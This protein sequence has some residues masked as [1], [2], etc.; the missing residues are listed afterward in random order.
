MTLLALKNVG[1]RFGGLKALD[2]VS[3]SVDSGEIV[4]I[5]G[6]NGAGKTTLFSL[7]AGHQKPGSGHILFDGRNI[8][9]LRPDAINRRGI[10]RTFQ[11]VRPFRS[12]T[13]RENVMIGALFG[14][15]AD[16]TLAAAEKDA[17]RILHEV[18]LAG[19]A[20]LPAG[21]LTLAGQKRLEIARALATRP[22]LLLLDEV[23]AGL[24]PT[25][26]AAARDMIRRLHKDHALT[27]LIIEHV[28]TA[29]MELGRR[30]V[31]LHHG[32]KIAEGTPDAIAASPRVQEAYLGQP[33]A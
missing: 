11:I 4:G 3:L 6:A 17:A 12:M 16:E 20:D 32:L 33:A 7:I 21:A 23:M 29:L 22:R 9:G 28:M 27:I 10:A 13:V 1:I 15:G 2:D 5:M 18:G 30:I 26:V 14:A 31:V 24:T 25:E 19:E 8:A